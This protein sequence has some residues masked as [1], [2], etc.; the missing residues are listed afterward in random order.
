MNLAPPPHPPKFGPPS[1]PDHEEYSAHD[2]AE[3]PLPK[4]GAVIKASVCVCVCVC[5]CVDI[6]AAPTMRNT[7]LVTGT[8]GTLLR[9]IIVSNC[10]TTAPLAVSCQ[11]PVGGGPDASSFGP[12]GPRRH[13]GDPGR[14]GRSDS[15]GLIGCRRVVGADIL[16]EAA[17][18]ARHGRSERRRPG[19]PTSSPPC[20]LDALGRRRP[21]NRHR[22]HT[23]T[24]QP[25]QPAHSLPRAAPSV[26][27]LRP[28]EPVSAHGGGPRRPPPRLR[29]RRH[30]WRHGFRV[31][32]Y[33][34]GP[35]F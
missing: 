26:A 21:E 23:G 10:V 17:Q 6:R 29:P 22:P 8:R 16:A 30:G 14:V 25:S 27:A 31:A 19:A 35:K 2:E 13:S 5:V 11:G 4:C 7:A 20:R 12:A 18:T 24:A 32:K 1:C 33:A 15:I 34:T 3:P 28:H 9:A